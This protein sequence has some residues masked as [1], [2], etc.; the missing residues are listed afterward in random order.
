MPGGSKVTKLILGT[1]KPDVA[2]LAVL[3]E[4]LKSGQTWWAYQNMALDSAS[5]GHLQFFCCGPHCTFTEPPA[6]M[7]DTAQCINWRYLL[8]GR[9]DLETGEIV[10]L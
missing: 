5:L 8:V 9:V 4:R 2:V 10:E 6:S 3:R 7:P 1:E